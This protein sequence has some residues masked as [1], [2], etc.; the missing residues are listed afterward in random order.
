MK[1]SHHQFT[2]FA[3]V[4]REGS[5][6]R[7]A[8]RLGVSQSAVTQHVTKLEQTVGMKLLQRGPDGI[9]LTR[10]GHELYDLADRQVTLD[11][12]IKEKLD[13][14]AA[15]ARGH[16]AII[17]NAPR[18]A[19]PLIAE[20]QKT[21]PNVEVDFTLYDWTQA[22]A[23]LRSRQVDVAVVTEPDRMGECVY[24]PIARASYV[25]YVP[26]Q[27]RLADKGSISLHDLTEE[28][29]LIPEEG[30]YTAKFIA[31]KLK[32][33]ALAFPRRMRTT[34]FPV[35]K[36]AILH[37]VGVGIF[38]A[39]SGFPGDGLTGL[40]IAEMPET[41]ETKLVVPKDK[42]G[43]RIVAGFTQLATE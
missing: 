26:D 7:A 33:H 5:F 2:A 29:V 16:L 41:F 43:L 22:M 36:E 37:G 11:G 18:P 30:S 8:G 39:D 17:A 25:G 10:A 42:W 31:Q 20:F 40:P 13:G 3:H 15:L 4:V 28:T 21:Y 23:L 1:A 14:Y 24:R 34:T 32:D 12:L 19:L 9:S 38:L 35:M 27:H 6:S